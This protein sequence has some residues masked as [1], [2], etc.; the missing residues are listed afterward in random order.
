MKIALVFSSIPTDGG[1][2]S[3]E[4]NLEQLM[5]SISQEDG[6]TLVKVYPSAKLK[7][8]SKS[9]HGLTNETSVAYQFGLFAK[10]HLWLLR[11]QP[12]RLILNFFRIDVTLV[13]RKLIKL[14]VDLVYFASPNPLALGLF[15]LPIATTVW[16]LGHRDVPE[17]PEL[18]ANGRWEN[19]ELYYS[20]SVPKSIF[21]CS[22]STSTK[23]Q[24]ERFY[25]LNPSRGFIVGLLPR[26]RECSCD[27]LDNEIPLGPYILYPAQ[28]WRHKNHALLLA[29]L[30]ELVD[31][32]SDIKLVFTGE[33]KGEGKQ[34]SY[35]SANLGIEKSVIDLGFISD[36]LLTHL[37]IS[38]ASVVMPSFLGP[39]NLP[40]LEA[41]LLGKPVVV[42][43]IHKF[44]NLPENAPIQL[45]DPNS[46]AEWALAISRSMSYPKFDSSQFQEDL[47]LSSRKALSDA[48]R[49][50]SSRLQQTV[51]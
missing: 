10:M 42:S 38:A 45:I 21:V 28:K 43:D 50:A 27:A 35:L 5:D 36:H 26:K 25:G 39:T 51:A 30:K 15:Q 41:I 47:E 11:T 2:F 19:R 16:D 6:H 12:G 24:L 31:N 3:Y 46:P 20:E 34:L 40:P 18:S 33:D 29:A 23:N 7:T 14:G 1:A 4:Q 49:L 44:D 32:G 9:G 17:F 37:L 8:S 13:E 22:D 48:L